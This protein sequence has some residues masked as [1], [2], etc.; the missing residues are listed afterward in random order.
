MFQQLGSE[1][2]VGEHVL[3]RFTLV[4]TVVDLQILADRTANTQN[5]FVH[6]FLQS[7]VKELAV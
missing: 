4:L 3:T 5:K 7:R 6:K 2:P 1:C